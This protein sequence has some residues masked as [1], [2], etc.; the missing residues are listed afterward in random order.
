[1]TE[2]PNEANQSSTLR[3][4]GLSDV[5]RFRKNNEDAFLALT[6]DARELKYLGKF[7]EGDLS[8][9]DFLFAV[10]DGMGGAK[11]G[12]FASKIAV[13]QITKLLPKSFNLSAQRMDAGLTDVVR[14][15]YERIHNTM[16]EMG[17][18]YEECSGM[19]ATLSLCWLMPEWIYFGHIGDSRIY[20]LPKEGPMIQVSEDHSY[21]GWLQRQGKLNEREARMHPQRHALN[22]ALGGGNKTIDPQ[23]GRIG[24]EAGDR[25]LICSD[26]V[27]DGLWNRKI[28]EL[29]R[30]TTID[31]GLNTV[32]MVREAVAESGRDNTTALIIELGCPQTGVL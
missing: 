28:E 25:L 24:W 30:K 14:E 6:F 29:A 22:Q 1:M 18:F 31:G 3:W 32:E 8:M 21:V 26:G 11:S 4:S 23:L 5:G 16:L 17:R 13:E 20:F 15:L 7:G 27:I 9:G 10:S 12:E 19:G 2:S